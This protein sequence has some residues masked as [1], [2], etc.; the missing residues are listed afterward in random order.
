LA[1]QQLPPPPNL[2]AEK[3]VLCAWPARAVSARY[4]ESVAALGPYLQRLLAC[5]PAVSAAREVPAAHPFPLPPGPDPP[6]SP[7]APRPHRSGQFSQSHRTPSA[8]P[9][10]QWSRS[11]PFRESGVE[12]SRTTF[13]SS[14]NV[15]WLAAG[16]ATAEAPAP[17]R[18]LHVR[19][20]FS[21]QA[22]LCVAPLPC[23]PAARHRLA[24]SL[25]CERTPH[26]GFRRRLS[27]ARIADQ[28]LVTLLPAESFL[29]RAI[30]RAARFKAT[31]PAAVS[32]SPLCPPRQPPPC[33]PP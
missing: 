11:P 27:L 23:S 12:R 25:A 31:S 7:S 13:K 15:G 28:T 5:L 3:G 2:A 18:H 33:R 24:P 30:A 8:C 14:R 9:Y 26:G 16:T 4:V 17:L 32:V 29:R 21:A 1:A 20:P 10:H 22:E 19:H 6:S